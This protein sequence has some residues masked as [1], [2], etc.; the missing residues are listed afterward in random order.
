MQYAVLKKEYLN[1]F[2][3]RL[4]QD[5]KVIAP[6]AK[7]YNQFAFE[8]V[9]SGEKVA[10]D[11]IP[12]IL[13]PK[14]YFMPQYE[15][16]ATYHANSSQ[17]MNPVV[18]CEDLILFGVHTCDLAGIQCLNMVFSERPKDIN[19]LIRKS[20]ITIIG[21]GC[22]DYCDEYAS[23]RLV[24]SHTPNGGYD[25]FFINLGDK[26]FVHINTLAGD[27]I[28]EKTNLFEPATPAD[29]NA[30][31]KI[32]EKKREIF[33][34]EVPVVHERMPE[35]FS[36]SYDSNVWEDLGKR[37]LA[38]G[39]CTN[40]CPTCYCFDVT[41]EPNLDLQT[42]KRFRRWDSCQ[43]E[44][45]AKVAGGESFRKERSARQRH[46]YFRKFKYPMEKFSRLF[47]TGCGRCSRTCMAKIN[48]KETLNQ[49]V[50]EQG[51]K[52]LKAGRETE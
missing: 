4:A 29:L 8:E 41:D 21:Y 36:K 12:T 28:T 24:H 30:L 37:C 43:N 9:K 22:N 10:L 18:E 13:P 32:R 19:Y 51:M 17:K 3:T 52:N 49:L 40:V 16:L 47:C 6:V 23:C 15:T 39:N 42:G 1:E 26:F 20:K 2:I 7:G 25:L 38:C 35:M 46:R 50:E 5:Q 48:L 45:F 27:E 31:A 33:A 14:K 44:A 11:H 34:N